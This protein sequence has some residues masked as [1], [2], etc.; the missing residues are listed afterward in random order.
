MTPPEAARPNLHRRQFVL[1]GL[2]FSSHSDTSELSS[3]E[4]IIGVGDYR[5]IKALQGHVVD[6]QNDD[7][8]GEDYS[9]S[10]STCRVFF[11]KDDEELARS[12]YLKSV[13]AIDI[14]DVEFSP[15]CWASKAKMARALD[16]E[17]FQNAAAKDDDPDNDSD[18]YILRT[19]NERMYVTSGTVKWAAVCKYTSERFYTEEVP[20][21]FLD[22][23]FAGYPLGETL[24]SDLDSL[25]KNYVADIAAVEAAVD[26]AIARLKAQGKM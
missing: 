8:V 26:G 17:A 22:V 25:I 24:S 14:S 4:N 16:H 10:R 5:E 11:R 3:Y 12:A 13:H 20:I 15:A 23:L 21:A 2:G 19:E 7:G 9:M 18:D 6:A 1:Y